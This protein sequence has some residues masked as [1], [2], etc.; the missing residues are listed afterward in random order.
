MCLCLQEGAFTNWCTLTNA[1]STNYGRRLDFILLDVEL[2][3]LCLKSADILQD[4]EGS[5]HCPITVDLDCEPIPPKSCP[6]LCTKYMPEFQ[7]KQQ[8]LSNFFI[9]VDKQAL[10]G[11]NSSQVKESNNSEDKCDR[12]KDDPYCEN[13]KLPLTQNSMKRQP[14]IDIAQSQSL[15]K[16]K[17]KE[18]KKSSSVT[19]H[20][21]LMSFFTAK[22]NKSIMEDSGSSV[23]SS[24]MKAGDCKNALNNLSVKP[25]LSPKKSKTEI[26]SQYFK[27]GNNKQINNGKETSV[28]PGVG[29]ESHKEGPHKETI[30]R[31]NSQKTASAWKNLL[32]GL[33]PAPVCKGHNETCVLRMVK[34]A[35][36]NKGRQFYTCARGEGLKTN[37][38]ARCDFFKWIDKKK[39]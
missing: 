14:D 4:T 16:Q 38:E 12:L 34:K 6:S 5:D 24:P 29:K 39:S 8:K 13:E 33:G 32:G 23:K 27:S 20:G 19:K 7:G 11:N 17:T 31:E 3:E 1:R 10:Q 25:E 21:N 30:V 37:P 15:K 26:T 18:M 35:G 28:S 9:K 2:S 22:T 36:P